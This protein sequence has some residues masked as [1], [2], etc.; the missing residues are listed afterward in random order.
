VKLTSTNTTYGFELEE[1][2]VEELISLVNADSRKLDEK[3][4]LRLDRIHSALLSAFEDGEE[5]R[6]RIVGADDVTRSRV[7][8]TEAAVPD[9]EV[10]S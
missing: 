1:V 6:D 5:A 8:I 7:I 3:R 10:E 2:D 4:E 9:G